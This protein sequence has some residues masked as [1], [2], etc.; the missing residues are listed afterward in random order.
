MIDELVDVSVENYSQVKVQVHHPTR[1]MNLGLFKA[2]S[3]PSTPDSR[4]NSYPKAAAK[5]YLPSRPSY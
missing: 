2:Y 4:Q 1:Q 5:L 3:A